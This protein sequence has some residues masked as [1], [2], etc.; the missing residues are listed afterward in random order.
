[1]LDNTN[2][3]HLD[4][5]INI[6]SEILSE[7]ITLTTDTETI[8]P[9]QESVNMEVHKHPHHVSHKKK[10]GEYLLE[11]LMIFLAVFLGFL[12][13]YQLEHVIEK[14][15]ANDFALSLQRDLV[16]DTAVFNMNIE[17]LI[18][19]K[20]KID[21]LVG[22][23]NNTKEAQK[24]VSFIYNL[25][26]YA[27]I[28]PIS[29]PTESTL[30]QLLNS[31]SLRYL[32]DNLLVDSIKIYNSNIQLFKNFAAT[33]SS[34][35]N[36]FRKSQLQVIEINPVIQFLE[37]D[38]LLSN[39]TARNISDS[40]FFSNRQLLTIEPLR[41]KEYANWCALKNFYLT[42][43]IIFYKKLNQ[44]ATDVLRLLNKQYIVE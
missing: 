38:G 9:N 15:R 33:S 5:P 26:A 29:T 42:N 34:F 20:K 23:L 25:S 18:I 41:L 13:E 35:N 36:E 3:G 37:E 44:Q 39:S 40:T 16:T 31:G 7:D 12:A 22:I 1:M 6:Q 32:K 30:Q 17:R 28:L 2:E 11:F 27:F 21:T 24:K 8:N 19:S 43:T 10:W 14:Q 4:I